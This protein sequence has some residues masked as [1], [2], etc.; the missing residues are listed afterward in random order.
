MRILKKIGKGFLVLIILVLYSCGSA[1]YSC[2]F[3]T[4]KEL[5][6]SNGKWLLNRTESNSK[7]FDTE[8]YHNSLKNFKN[9]LGDS[10]IE[11]NDLRSTKLVAPK[12]KFDLSTLD[13]QELKRDTDCDYII[14]IGGNIISDGAGTLT[15][16]NQNENSS[17]RASVSISIYDLNTE[18]LISSSQ[19]YGKTENQ[20]SAFDN[21]DNLPTINPSSH[22]IMLKGA[23]KLIKK[24]EKNQ[25]N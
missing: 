25:L 3:D 14:N 2:L 4:G 11:I 24:Y 18:T 1:K 12:I 7:I 15:F 10:L 21:N 6:F 17:N 13:L 23:K 5:D 9:I 19:V 20:A 22:M 16:S 8:L